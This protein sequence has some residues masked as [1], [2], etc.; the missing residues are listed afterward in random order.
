LND[1]IQNYKEVYFAISKS[2]SETETWL[3]ILGIHVRSLTDFVSRRDKASGV[4]GGFNATIGIFNVHVYI[5]VYIYIKP[6]TCLHLY[7][8]IFMYI[9]TYTHIIYIYIYMYVYTLT[10]KPPPIAFKTTNK[11]AIIKSTNKNPQLTTANSFT[12][13]NVPSPRPK[14][15]VGMTG[16]GQKGSNASKKVHSFG[17]YIYIYIYIYYTFMFLLTHQ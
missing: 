9:H 12:D 10:G 3:R 5:Y 6:C 1:E 13:K 14:P 16:T 8:F 2:C 4:V 17:L 11:G 7:I 15:G